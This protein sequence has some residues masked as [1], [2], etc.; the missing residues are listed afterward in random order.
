MAW[1]KSPADEL[2]A[3]EAARVAQERAAQHARM[4]PY[5]QQLLAVL[6][7]IRDALTTIAALMP[8]PTKTAESVTPNRF[9]HAR[10]GPGHPRHGP[11]RAPPRMNKGAAPLPPG[12]R[13][14]TTTGTTTRGRKIR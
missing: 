4:T 5:Q 12:T 14:P 8:Y 10:R 2:A 7:E 3:D 6:G 13:P 9:G 1:G 11:R